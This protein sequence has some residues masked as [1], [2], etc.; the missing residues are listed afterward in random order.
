VSSSRL[1][2]KNL[3]FSTGD[4]LLAER[5][6]LAIDHQIVSRCTSLMGGV[7]MFFAS[8]YVFGIEYSGNISA[9]MDFMQRYIV[10]L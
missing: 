6:D 2:N 10:F 3:F 5:F 7:G 1:I 4:V 9:T 8:F